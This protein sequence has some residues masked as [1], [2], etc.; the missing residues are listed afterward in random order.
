MSTAPQQFSP[1]TN[2]SS[3]P[4]YTLFESPVFDYKKSSCLLCNFSG[5]K[6]ELI[7][8]FSS[9]E[10]FEKYQQENRIPSQDDKW[11]N[12][13]SDETEL[14]HF[15]RCDVAYHVGKLPKYIEA[16]FAYGTVF[17]TSRA[18]PFNE[19]FDARKQRG[20]GY[21]CG[22]QYFSHIYGCKRSEFFVM[23]QLHER[24]GMRA[25]GSYSFVDEFLSFQREI[26]KRQRH[27][28]EQILDGMRVR[29]YWDL[30]T[31]EKRDVEEVISLFSE[32]RKEYCSLDEP[33]FSILDS[34]GCEGDGYKFSLHLVGSCVHESRAELGK[35]CSSFIE[36]LKKQEKYFSLFTLIDPGVYTKNRA[37]RCVGSRKYDS[38][39]TLVIYKSLSKEKEDLFVT[40][41]QEKLNNIWSDSERCK[42]KDI[43]IAEKDPKPEKIWKE[44]K[45]ELHATYSIS[46]GYMDALERYVREKCNDAFAYNRDWRGGNT[47]LLLKRISGR[48]NICPACSEEDGNKHDTRDAYVRIRQTDG[49]LMFGCW[50]MKKRRVIA[51]RTEEPKKISCISPSVKDWNFTSDF[52][53]CSSDVL[54]MCL[55]EEKNCFLLRSAMGTGKTKTAANLIANNKKAKILV[56][57]FRIS[58]DEELARKLPGAVLYSDPKAIKKGF[59][60]SDVLVCQ[61]DSIRKVMGKYDIVIIDEASSTLNHLCKFVKNAPDC[62]SAMKEFIQKAKQVYFLDALMENYVVDFA[63]ALGKQCHVVGD[64]YMPHTNFTK[65]RIILSKKIHEE[66]LFR[67]LARKE[68]IGYTSNSK[69]SV[70][71]IAKLAEE[72]GYR[73][74]KYTSETRRE[75]PIVDASEWVNYD[76]V[77]YTPTIS[78]GISFEKKHFDRV[79][80]YF[81]N[82]SASAEECCQ[83]LFRIRDL[84]EKELVINIKQIPSNEPIT[85]EGVV[86][87]LENLDASS[88]RVCGL[89]YNRAE[90]KLKRTIFSNLYIANEARNNKSKKNFLVVLTSLLQSQG[91]SV[92]IEKPKDETKET[93]DLA[94]ELSEI[95]KMTKEEELKEFV[96]VP[97]ITEEDFEEL[98]N[99]VEKTK[100]QHLQYKKFKLAKHFRMEQKDVSVE[101]LKVYKKQWVAYETLNLTYG[102]EQEISEKLKKKMRDEVEWYEKMPEPNK[103]KRKHHLEKIIVIRGLLKILG[104]AEWHKEKI[105]YKKEFESKLGEAYGKVNNNHKTFSALFGSIPKN[106]GNMFRW[107]NVVLRYLYGFVFKKRKGDNSDYRCMVQFSVAWSF[108]NNAQ[109]KNYCVPQIVGTPTL[110]YI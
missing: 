30:E 71:T 65:A 99:I 39:R 93:L 34:S 24:R 2:I 12:K 41:N 32:A 52:E 56:L 43:E 110:A 73:V 14:H 17:F 101:F 29:E 58:L 55:P 36:W 69:K 31:N 9:E 95:E 38:K 79:F 81:S 33:E 77:V 78:A 64:T 97:E 7:S 109:I 22:P 46:E 20:E 75:F 62:W 5:S 15:L 74:K 13:K 102:E 61:I 106:K 42:K 87:K 66:E 49:A 57:S 94:K 90:R 103:L 11:W 63:K 53:Y 100:E 84:A 6:E 18:T 70:D 91:V 26:P 92:E 21:L 67:A 16:I 23:C 35:F 50:K 51:F 8:H 83:M 105:T 96:A 37:F 89:K 3:F 60:Q 40:G 27:F 59:I 104:Y 108:K 28:N 98:S 1:Q 68:K 85:I 86:E 4:I 44:Q 25:F 82:K 76:L 80:G 107:L 10:H 88:Y 19:R 47:S 48:S 45:E 72:K 54:P